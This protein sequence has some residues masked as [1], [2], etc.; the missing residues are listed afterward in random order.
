M[1]RGEKMVAY[2]DG[3]FVDMYNLGTVHYSFVPWSNLGIPTFR[4]LF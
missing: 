2:Q 4:N 1:E 3:D